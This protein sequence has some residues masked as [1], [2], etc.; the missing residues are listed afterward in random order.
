MRRYEELIVDLLP[1]DTP[2]QKYEMFLKIVDNSNSL[3]ILLVSLER[4]PDSAT[5]ENIRPWLPK[6]RT[7]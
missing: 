1:G 7:V 5:L 4:T 3:K 6:D 2:K